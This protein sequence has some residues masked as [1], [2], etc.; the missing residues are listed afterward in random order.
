MFSTLTWQTLFHLAIFPQRFLHGFADIPLYEF[1][2]N[3][4]LPLQFI[5]IGIIQTIRK[6]ELVQSEG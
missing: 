6:F 1:E 2:L 5:L 4:A 3:P